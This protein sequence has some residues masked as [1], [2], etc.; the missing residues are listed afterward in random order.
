M[1]TDLQFRLMDLLAHSEYNSSNGDTPTTHTDVNTWFWADE[2]AGEMG[3]SRKA[4]G[5]VISSLIQLGFVGFAEANKKMGDTDASA[6]FTEAG[7]AAWWDER[8][9]E[10]DKQA[11]QRE[12]AGGRK[13][14]P[15]KVRPGRSVKMGYG[16]RAGYQAGDRVKL[17]EEIK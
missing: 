13:P 14:K 2:L 4:V 10:I 11:A 12:A 9:A 3:I 5:G 17:R 6:W 15:R 7:F 16:A 1:L 8:L